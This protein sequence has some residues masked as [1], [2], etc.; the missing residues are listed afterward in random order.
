MQVLTGDFSPLSSRR[1]ASR[2]VDVYVG[3]ERFHYAAH[4]AFLFQSEEL[5]H[6]YDSQNRGKKGTKK[7]ENVLNLPRETANEFGQLLEYLYVGKLTLHASEPEAQADE[8]LTIWT[9]GSRHSLRGMQHHVIHKLEE[10]DLASKLPTLAFL[11]LADKLYESEVDNGLRRYFQKVATEVVGRITT[12]DMPVLLEMITE[13]GSF[14][15]DLFHAHHQA[16]GPGKSGPATAVTIK[17][18]DSEEQRAAKRA[19]TDKGGKYPCSQEK[20]FD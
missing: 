7:K 8:L 6:Q 3:D 15:S 4:E 2:V 14:A 18:E 13:G 12:A 5:K 16:F 19:R 17:V 9:M 10:L 20:G 1:F 11:R